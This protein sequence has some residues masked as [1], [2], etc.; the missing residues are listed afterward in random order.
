MTG[1]MTQQG[2]LK[3]TK[4]S[5]VKSNQQPR[6]ADPYSVVF[7]VPLDFLDLPVWQLYHRCRITS[8]FFG[9]NCQEPQGGLGY[10]TN[11]YSDKTCRSPDCLG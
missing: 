2:F 3:L 10:G 8:I 1:S 5:S 9:D 7:V 4:E 11:N 6:N